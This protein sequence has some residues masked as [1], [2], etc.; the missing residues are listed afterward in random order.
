[1]NRPQI[2]ENSGA[3]KLMFPQEA[4][5]RNFTLMHQ[6]QQLI[7]H[8]QYIVRSGVELENVQTYE[9][10]LNQIYIGKFQLC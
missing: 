3:T 2:H 10:T 8:I 5:L 6:I 9:N 7:W 4:R 1:M